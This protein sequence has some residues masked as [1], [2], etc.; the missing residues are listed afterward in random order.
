MADYTAA[1]LESWSYYQYPKLFMS[2]RSNA[3]LKNEFGDLIRDQNGQKIIT[4]KIRETSSYAEMSDKA[5]AL[6]MILFD[7][8]GRAHV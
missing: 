6:Y 4:H 8:I 1:D 2:S 5:K 3:Y 7:Q